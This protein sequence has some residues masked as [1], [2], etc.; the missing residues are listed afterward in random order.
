MT[1]M[2]TKRRRQYTEKCA[3]LV[4]TDNRRRPHNLTE[5]LLRV[6]IARPWVDMLLRMLLEVAEGRCNAPGQDGVLVRRFQA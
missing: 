1:Q 3:A 2:V 4:I 6:L 5:R